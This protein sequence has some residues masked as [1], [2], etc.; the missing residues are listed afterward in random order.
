[1]GAL[2][3]AKGY[4]KRGQGELDNTYNATY[5]LRNLINAGYLS[6]QEGNN[7][8]LDSG[9]EDMTWQITWAES[10]ETFDEELESRLSDAEGFVVFVH[11]WTGT[12]AIWE[13]LPELLAQANR[14]LI[15]IA[16]DH[17]GFG[18]SRFV[19]DPEVEACNPP[20]A[21]RTLQRLVDVLKIRRQLGDPNIKVINFVGHSMGGATLFYCDPLQW[22]YGEYTR[23]ALA[24]ALLLEDEMKQ[25][26]YTSM[27][28]GLNLVRRIPAFEIIYQAV[29]PHIL[30]ILCTGSTDQVKQM[31]RVQSDVV[32]R[33]TTGATIM[34]MGVLRDREIPRNFD[35]FRVLLGHR[36]P[37]VGLTPALDLMMK[38]E[39]PAAHLR[40]VPGTHYMFSVGQDYAFQHAQSRE[41]VVEDIL[42]LHAKAYQMQKIGQR[43]G[44]SAGFG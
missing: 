32:G 33:G 8:L 18:G 42:E 9:L 22:R 34:A 36:D 27:G 13:R 40:V 20:A 43:V 16:I 30:G 37:L 7:L 29:K 1:M 12:F 35:L 2:A 5:S 19:A 15:S 38:L 10:Y 21:M 24:P 4:T 25:A 6:A 17:N 28:I 11:G 31:H 41:L 14:R 26:F 23:Y 44:G 3:W 39:F